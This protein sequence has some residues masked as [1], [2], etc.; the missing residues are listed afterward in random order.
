VAVCDGARLAIAEVIAGKQVVV[1]KIAL[2]AIGSHCLAI[3]PVLGQIE[4]EVQFDQL[5]RRG[6]EP[7]EAHV[8]SVCERQH[9]RRH[10]GVEM[11]CG[12]GW[13]Q[14]AT[15]RENRY[16]VPLGRLA[17]LRIDTGERSEVPRET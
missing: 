12:L 2:G 15:H 6:F 11:A 16:Q 14:I 10:S 5:A 9:M 7:L 8:P 4:P 17:D 13:T 3:A 1:V